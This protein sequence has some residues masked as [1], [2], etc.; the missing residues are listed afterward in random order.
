MDL[1]KYQSESVSMATLDCDRSLLYRAVC[2]GEEAGEVLGKI[3]RVMR[4]DEGLLSSQ[5]RL[6]I[7]HELGDVLF[8]VAVMGNL[9]GYDLDLIAR[10]NLAKCLRRLKHGTVHGSGDER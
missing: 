6:Q 3:K 8:N 4:D 10:S 1:N 7:A 5:M 2:L 9:I